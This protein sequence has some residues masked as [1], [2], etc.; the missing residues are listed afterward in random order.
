MSEELKQKVIAYY[1]N[2]KFPAPS[3]FSTAEKF[4]LDVV[5]VTKI[6]KEA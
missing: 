3:V 1:N 2:G 5:E 6:L 4:N